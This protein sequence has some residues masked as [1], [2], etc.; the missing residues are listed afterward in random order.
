M[1]AM[2]GSIDWEQVRGVR[3]Y[4]GVISEV[5]SREVL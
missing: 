5:L 3:Q 2:E 1:H 4:D